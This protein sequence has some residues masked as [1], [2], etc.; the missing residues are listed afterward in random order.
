MLKK[1]A[2]GL[3]LVLASAQAFAQKNRTHKASDDNSTDDDSE[4]QT[5]IENMLQ[6]SDSEDFSFDTQFEYLEGYATNPIDLNTASAKALEEFG[7]LSE[8]QVQGLVNYRREVGQVFSVYELLNVPSWDRVT[9]LKVL[10]YV[11]LSATKAKEPF[12]FARAFK[13]SRSTLFARYQR[14]V[15]E[16]K[17]Y[18]PREEGSTA[19]R[20]LGSP[21]RIYSRYRLTY[22]D[23]MSIGLTM[24]KDAGEE[25][26]KGSN[27]KGF[28]FYSGHFYLK[29]LNK[30]VAAVVVGDFQI[31]MGQ[32]LLM[33]AGFGMRKSPAVLNVKRIASPIRAYTSANEAQ[34]MRG[35]ATTLQ[36]GK[37]NQWEVTPF[38]SYRGRDA[39]ISAIDTLDGEL[40]ETDIAEVSSFQNFGFHRTASEIADRNSLKIFS[41]GATI[42][43]RGDNWHIASNTV[44]NRLSAPLNRGSDPYQTFFFQGQQLLNTSLDYSYSYKQFQFFG[45]TALSDNGGIATS[46]GLLANLDP[47]LNFAM[48]YRNYSRNYQHIFGNS[49]GERVG[50]NN[51]T[52]IYMGLEAM[53]M[54]GLKISGYVDMYK[55]PWLTSTV[56]APSHGVEGF[57]RAGV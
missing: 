1:Y 38:V 49:F 8:L 27:K 54:A 47:K 7:M 50:V 13:Y 34:F 23:R 29:D 44:F 21:D 12:S 35:A 5:L 14:I 33:W 32:G 19:Q 42:K 30:N 51:E 3:L 39:N 22:K 56:D 36:F 53:P 16:Q 26:F 46:N 41:T 48:L 6:D 37:R 24:E 52:G 2:A 10:P 11:T 4:M 40:F 20:Y 28:D 15:E 45:E 18:T 9:V 57:L 43:Y 17:G 55:F 25:F 31:Y